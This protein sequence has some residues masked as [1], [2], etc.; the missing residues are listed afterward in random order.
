[1]VDLL[2]GYKPKV[3]AF[4]RAAR[5]R[6]QIAAGGNAEARLQFA[7]ERRV[8]HGGAAVENHAAD[9]AFRLKAQE[10]FDACQY[11]QRRAACVHDQNGRA[12]RLLR[13]LKGACAC[14]GQPQPVIVAH[15]ALDDAHAAAAAVFNKQRAQ[16]VVRKEERVEV[17]GFC[18]D[19]PAVKHRVNVVRS[20]FAGGRLETAVHK[21][22]QNGAGDGRFAAAAVRS[23]KNQPG[24]GSLHQITPPARRWLQ[25]S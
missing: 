7:R 23:G 16:R 10:A 6:R 18:A 22:L 2:R 12:L 20:A 21:R 17:R 9:A 19:N 5:E 8:A 14:R 15:D 25:N 4:K 3:A 1:M 24:N 11:G 13:K